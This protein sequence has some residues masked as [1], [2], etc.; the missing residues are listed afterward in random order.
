MSLKVD[1]IDPNDAMLGFCCVVEFLGKS[2][3]ATPKRSVAAK[4]PTIALLDFFMPLHPKEYETHLL[5]S[6]GAREFF[7]SLFHPH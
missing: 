3:K 1:L 5:F 2:G 6:Q 7:L 4:V